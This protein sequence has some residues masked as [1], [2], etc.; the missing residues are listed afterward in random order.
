MCPMVFDATL[1]SAFVNSVAAIIQGVL[2]F[3][4]RNE[5]PSLRHFTP[6]RSLET[7]KAP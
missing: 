1:T 3:K 5:S 4:E 2:Y 7:L 6:D